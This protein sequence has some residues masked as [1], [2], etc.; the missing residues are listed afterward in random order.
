MKMIIEIDT[1]HGRVDSL[2]A[3]LEA[4]SGT[5][6]GMIIDWSYSEDYSNTLINEQLDRIQKAIAG[7]KR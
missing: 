5:L 4:V 3:A 7:L 6:S 2:I 1:K